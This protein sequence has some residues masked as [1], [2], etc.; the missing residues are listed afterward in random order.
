MFYKINYPFHFLAIDTNYLEKLV[1]TPEIGCVEDGV[2]KKPGV[3]AVVCLGLAWT[4][5]AFEP[6]ANS[7]DLF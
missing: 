4:C 1:G 6:S 2:G 5:Y 7:N 3:C